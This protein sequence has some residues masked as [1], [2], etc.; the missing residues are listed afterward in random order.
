M[1]MPNQEDLLETIGI[2]E[3]ALK[4]P[5]ITR[6]VIVVICDLTKGISKNIKNKK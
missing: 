3:S 6:V 2:L 5:T 4:V 1:T